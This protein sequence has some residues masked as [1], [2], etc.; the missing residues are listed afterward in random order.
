MGI[1]L[2]LVQPVLREVEVGEV[3]DSSWHHPAVCRRFF[4]SFNRPLIPPL[5]LVGAT[6]ALGDDGE[7][8]AGLRRTCCIIQSLFNAPGSPCSTVRPRPSPWPLARPCPT[9]ATQRLPLAVRP[10]AEDRQRFQVAA[11]GFVQIVLH[12]RQRAQLT[13]SDS[14]TA[15]II[16][17]LVDFKCCLILLPRRVELPHVRQHIGQVGV[18]NTSFTFHFVAFAPTA[19]APP[20]ACRCI[21]AAAL[22]CPCALRQRPN[23]TKRQCPF[24]T[25]RIAQAGQQIA[26]DLLRLHR[27]AHLQQPLALLLTASRIRPRDRGRRTTDH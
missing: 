22:C 16:A 4:R 21:S 26:K 11:A 13:E 1:L 6:C 7:L 10:F 27:A 12:Q 23:L 14:R 24:V 15:L 2:R 5:R 17:I 25:R 3:V 20:T 18:G 19:P 9:G 8:V